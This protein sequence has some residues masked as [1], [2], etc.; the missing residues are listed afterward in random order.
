LHDDLD[1]QLQMRG[2]R[3]CHF[4][5][6]CNVYTKLE[7]PSQRVMARL[8]TFLETKLRVSRAKGGM[9]RQ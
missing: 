2:Y 5:D 6:D 4:A 1:K 9:G 7:R 8:Y 3:A